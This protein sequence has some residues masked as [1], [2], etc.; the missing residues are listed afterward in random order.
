MQADPAVRRLLA[1]LKNKK[2]SNRPSVKNEKVSSGPSD[3]TG[4]A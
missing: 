1:S 4:K 2:M 3:K